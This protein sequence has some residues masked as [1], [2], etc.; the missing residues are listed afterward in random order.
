MRSA[1]PCRWSDFA[2]ESWRSRGERELRVYSTVAVL[3]GLLASSTLAALTLEVSPS[4]AGT[5]PGQNGKLFCAGRQ[6]VP[7]I[8]PVPPSQ[9]PS[10]GGDLE[11]FSMNPDGSGIQYLTDNTL[12]DPADPRSFV[13]DNDPAVSPDGTK[14]A[15]DSTLGGSSD[16]YLMNAD[17][18]D[19]RRLTSAQGE[20]RGISWS[21]DGSKIYFHSQRDAPPRFE[22][23]SMNPDG[24]N[25]TN[26]SRSPDTD[27]FLPA[28]SVKGEV[29]FDRGFGAPR[30]IWKMNSDGTGVTRLT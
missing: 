24:T 17:G 16:V 21:P 5:F 13:E 25:Q 18:S 12:I 14:V 4:H 6:G 20:D 11:I 2:P 23:Y 3:A 8:P 30:E 19:Q 10:A 26:V 22:V 7:S 29:A 28:V 1:L 27:D 9:S 15:F